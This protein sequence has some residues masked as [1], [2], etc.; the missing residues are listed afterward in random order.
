MTSRTV[1]VH[2][3]AFRFCQQAQQPFEKLAG[4]TLPGEAETFADPDDSRVP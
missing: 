4:N 3:P 2:Y 1:L